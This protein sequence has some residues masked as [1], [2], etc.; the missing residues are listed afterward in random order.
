MSS[1][2]DR[3]AIAQDAQWLAQALDPAAG[4]VRLIAMSGE[5]YRAA[6]FLDDRMLQQPVDAHLVP[7]PEVEAAMLDGV[8]ND[9]R[10]IFHIGH[11][12]ST[13]ISRLLGEL[14]NVL[15]IR[16]PRI[17]RDLAMS[18]AE[19]RAG[20]IE[21]VPKLMSRTFAADEIACVKA[22]SLV[23]EIAS[24]LVPANE[25]AIFMFATPRNYIA[26]IL[27]G[28]NSVQELRMLGDS[29]AQRM[30]KRV[31]TMAV[32]NDAELAG[33]AWACEMTSLEAAVEAMPDRKITWAD[34][35]H[36]LGDMHL[37]LARAAAFF[38]FST[39]GAKL[40]AI[41]QGPLVARY[42]KAPEYAYS[43]ALRGELIAEVSTAQGREIVDALAM[44]GRAA[45]KS[46]LLAR[47]L[48]RAGEA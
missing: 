34:F 9:A 19:I 12:G 11:V 1:A 6:S 8:R 16:E 23:S 31:G 24:D 44:L 2:P 5:A 28:E 22:T 15:A 13:L 25:R 14:S 45:E 26:S 21:A 18:P 33:A 17:L 10:W 3:Q 36:M 20:Y 38:G 41:A 39:D 48:E 7:W 43:P 46:P 37:E 30:A 29:R 47:A 40:A 32:R 4:M 42:S 35:D 27:A